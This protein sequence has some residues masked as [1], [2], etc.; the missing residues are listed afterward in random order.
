MDE[1][2]DGMTVR[3]HP[4]TTVHVWDFEARESAIWR[5]GGSAA[6]HEFR[7]TSARE[8]GDRGVYLTLVQP[9]FEHEYEIH[10]HSSKV[11]V[12]RGAWLTRTE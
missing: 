2:W 4:G 1:A 6:G 10:V 9:G 7:V 5:I 11:V 8:T 12:V 3:I